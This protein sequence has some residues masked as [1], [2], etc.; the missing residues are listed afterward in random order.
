MGLRGFRATGP[1]EENRTDKCPLNTVNDL[2]KEDCG[3]FDH[4]FNVDSNILMV[5]L[6]DKC[7]NMAS[8]CDNVK[9][10]ENVYV[11]KL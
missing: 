6:H 8:N 10:L 5:R 3:S 4:R 9:P 11:T 7:V 1:V 2:S